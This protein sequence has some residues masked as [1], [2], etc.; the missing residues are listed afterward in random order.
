MTREYLKLFH[1]LIF[2]DGVPK[3]GFMWFQPQRVPTKYVV[4]LWFQGSAK[5]WAF[6]QIEQGL[7][8]FFA[9]FLAYLTLF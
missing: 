5:K 9:K 3:I 1:Y 6:R 7:S 2:W 8:S 4:L